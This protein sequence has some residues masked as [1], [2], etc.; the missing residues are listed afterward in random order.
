MPAVL[1]EMFVGFPQHIQANNGKITVTAAF[2]TSRFIQSRTR[3][4]MAL[5][6]EIFNWTHI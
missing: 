4:V 1:T 5:N 2:L 3:N 6:K